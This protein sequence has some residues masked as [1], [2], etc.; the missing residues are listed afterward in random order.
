MQILQDFSKTEFKKYLTEKFDVKPFVADQIFQW[1]NRGKNFSEMSN[2]SKDLREE[3]ESVAIAQAVEIVESKSSKI[4]NTKKFLFKLNDGNI[5]E[6][7]LMSYKYGNTICVST[8]VGCRMGCKFCASTKEGLVRNLSAGEILAQVVAVNC[9]GMEETKSNDRFITNIVLMGSGEPLDNFAEVLKFIELV[10]NADGLNISQRNISLST[11]GL[12]PEIHQLAEQNLQIN[13]VVSLHNATQQSREKI[14]P[15]AKKYDVDSV[16][17]SAKYYFEK[18]KRRVIFE[19][20]LIDGENDSYSDA[21]KLSNKLRGFSTHVNLIRLNPIKEAKNL[22]A[23]TDANAKKFLG[24]LTKLNISASLR[25][26]LGVDIDGA[27]GQLRQKFVG[28]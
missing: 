19:Y 28:E 9:L 7:V 27:C 11:C 17:S 2:I 22:R 18:T 14:M 15:I 4:D 6:G 26:Q 23:T 12:V 16:I 5:V 25:R 1:L 13:L 21:L 20:T 3:L 8:Q 10:S 24:Y